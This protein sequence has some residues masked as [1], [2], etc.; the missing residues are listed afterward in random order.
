[1][2]T[3]TIKRNLILFVI[4]LVAVIALFAALLLPNKAA[5]ALELT[6][7]NNAGS[8]DD[9]SSISLVFDVNGQTQESNARDN[10]RALIE[11]HNQL[12]Q[13]KRYIHT[14]A[15]AG[16]ADGDI[17][18]FVKSSIINGNTNFTV[19]LASNEA[20]DEY[21]EVEALSVIESEGETGYFSVQ[22]RKDRT[23]EYH[24][25]YFNVS[26]T[27][28]FVPWR[29]ITADDHNV[30]SLIVGNTV[31]N[32]TETTPSYVNNAHTHIMTV[33]N[34]STITINLN[35]YLLG[36]ALYNESTHAALR[37]GSS[38][39]TIK[40]VTNFA[41]DSLAFRGL[42]L[43]LKDEIK[44][45]T[46]SGSTFVRIAP[47]IT[48]RVEVD[49]NTI[50]T[51]NQQPGNSN[52]QFWDEIHMMEL[53]LKLV[54]GQATAGTTT[55]KIVIPFKFAPANP[56]KK[57]ISPNYLRLN[58]TSQNTWDLNSQTLIKTDS[59]DESSDFCSI[60]LRPSDL[61]E[62]SSPTNTTEYAPY[63]SHGHTTLNGDTNLKPEGL[64][65]ERVKRDGDSY[66]LDE[67]TA[68]GESNV[69]PKI[70]R[71]TGKRSTLANSSFT[72]NFLIHYYTSAD[73]G[74]GHDYER[75]IVITTYG[76]YK[77]KFS[78]INGKKAVS[79]N[80]LNSSVFTEMR[81][82]GYLLTDAYSL[83]ENQLGVNFS[84]NVL[85]LDPKVDNINGQ[86]SAR[87]MLEFTNNDRQVITFESEVVDINV[88]AGSLF[89]RFD[90]WQAW[91]II[92]AVAL[93]I[94]LIILLV[95]WLV[96]RAISKH[97]QDELAMQAPVSSYIVKLNSTIAATQAQQRAAQNQA[98][99]QA[100]TQMLLGAGPATG[101]APMPDTLQLASGM[102]SSP[103]S[104]N[105]STPSSPLM[106]E[107]QATMPPDGDENLEELIAKY[108]SDDELLERIFTEKYEPKG[109]VRRT[110][111]KSKDLQSRELE[112]EKKRIIERYKTPMPMDEAIMS[113]TEI[114]NA[115]ATST[116]SATSAPAEP[117]PAVVEYFVLDFDPDSPLYVEEEKAPDEF[118][119]EKIDIDTSPE[120]SRLRA[121]EHQNDILN[122]E[123]AELKSRLDKV[124]VEV[125]RAKTMEDELREKIAKAES[126]DAQYSKDIE[127]LEFK[128]ASAKNKD[129]EK[130]T[131]D[132]GIKEEKKKRNS[133]E[134]ERLRQELDV[135]L[136]NGDRINGIYAKLNDLQQ[137]KNSDLERIVAERE[138]AKAEYEGYLERMEIIRKKQELEAKVVSLE[139]LLQAVNS[140]DYE[141]RRIE[142][143]EQ[144][145]AKERES[146]KSEV[147][148]AKAQ[149][150][151]TTD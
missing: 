65:I 108:I 134:L 71:I 42:S 77:I 81:G 33:P 87:V 79:Y 91:L 2:K 128:L 74:A 137:Q 95:V 133:E 110:F 35:D 125:D 46:P 73:S 143:V 122:K 48:G 80:V 27:D 121:L 58:V 75:S 104:P 49:A 39:W 72:I 116:P 57:E 84:N 22:V 55:Y 98:L 20:E 64:S 67:T 129:K 82:R 47:Y 40:S 147:A 60:I 25:V 88:N 54:K 97:K 31:T 1:M 19:K 56:Q 6:P 32:G 90:D 17:Y 83:N 18:Y 61:M 37:D 14:A 101:A 119:E 24:T 126:D 63:F 138:K 115:S 107:P 52:K 59:E 78:P 21:I 68:S 8:A 130:I 34:Y 112:K 120:E 7:G 144:E 118:T 51:F 92:A 117:E 141:M 23:T 66:V 109:M 106:S 96:F 105:M 132:I 113:E 93:G 43:T 26:I 131:R 36:R 145:Q 30:K 12:G 3:N 13:R 76:G 102:P 139:P 127:D 28:S 140:T 146:L 70:Y 148:Q 50:N 16:G 9:K 89:A 103:S 99:S 135:L 149:I 94:L 150:L 11:A 10:T 4:L 111:F 45:S 142:K 29:D 5:S 86:A 100:S 62:Y 114:K 123:L 15:V 41:I 69:V 44:S 124:Q 38:Q 151:G 53:T 85:T 136:G